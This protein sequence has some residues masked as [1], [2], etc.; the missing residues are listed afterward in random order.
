MTDAQIL[1]SAFHKNC[2]KYMN[3]NAKIKTALVK[4][5]GEWISPKVKPEDFPDETVEKIRKSWYNTDILNKLILK[6]FHEVVHK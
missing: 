3:T 5:A 2:G 4:T 1:L 6:A